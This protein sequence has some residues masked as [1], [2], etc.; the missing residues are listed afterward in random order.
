MR[1]ALP[2][3]ALAALFV[4]ACSGG[5]GA[6]DATA[7]AERAT[8]GAGETGTAGAEPEATRAP[9]PITDE[10][11]LALVYWQET[12]FW[13]GYQRRLRTPPESVLNTLAAMAVDEDDA[14]LQYLIDLAVLPVPYSDFAYEILLSTQPP[15]EFPVFGWVEGLG[16]RTPADDSAT[17]LQLK[18]KLIRGIQEQMGDFVDPAQPRTISAQEVCWGGVRVDGIPPLESPNFLTPEQAAAWIGPDDLVIGVEINGDARAY[19]RRIVDW[20]EMVNDTVGGVPVSLAYC[21]LC[22][23]AIL[24]DGRV[25]EEVYRFGTSGLLYRSNKLMYDRTTN[26]LWEQFTGEPVWGELVGS[27]I[28]L[29]FLPVVHM[30]YETW[31]KAHPDTL[32]LDIDTGH[33][34]NYGEGVA[35]APL[36]PEPAADVPRPRSLGTARREVDGLCGSAQRR[37]ARLPDL[38]AAG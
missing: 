6:S 21:T 29:K 27:G 17:Y 24:Y 11:L 30:T 31:L 14:Y 33:K 16:F 19:P 20:H 22:G 5:S 10:D 26:T 23:S 13:N 36:L 28:Q 35:Y 34:R 8:V 9:K 12:D 38:V 37:G 15:T 1:L 4:L 2:V 3:L 18:H 25:G 32:V 7:P